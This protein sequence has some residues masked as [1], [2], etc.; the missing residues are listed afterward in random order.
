[1]MMICNVHFSPPNVKALL[2]KAFFQIKIKEEINAFMQTRYFT[3]SEKDY[4]YTNITMQ[5]HYFL[6]N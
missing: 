5:E 6:S 3:K 4:C 2:E 1:M